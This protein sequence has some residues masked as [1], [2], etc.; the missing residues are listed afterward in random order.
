MTTQ[1]K[2]N[3]ADNEILSLAIPAAGAGLTAL[4]H[5]W[6]DT[7]WIG[8]SS[9]GALGVAA[10]GVASFTV[11][12]YGS[13]GS[14]LIVGL[15]AIVGRYCGAGRLAGACYTGSQGL[16]GAIWLAGICSL[17]GYFLAPLFFQLAGAGDGLLEVG[18]PYVRVYWGAGLPILLGYAATGIFRGHGD[19]RTP[20]L[21]GLVGLALN[22]VLDPVF[23]FGLG[24]L[25]AMGVE[26][27]AW[28]TV[29]C[30]GA[31]TLLMLWVLKKRGL[32]APARP[33]DEELRLR[34]DTPLSRPG[35]LGLDFAVLRRLVRIGQ[36]VAMAGIFFSLVYLLLARIVSATGGPTSVAA[37]S[38]GH[39]GEGLAWVFYTGYSAAA[40]SLVARYMGE[41]RT[42]LAE[43]LAWRAVSQ[44]AVLS[45]IWGGALFFFGE[46]IA[47]WFIDSKAADHE[48]VVRE[49]A[50]YFKITSWS[51]V[52]Q[53][54]DLVLGGAFSGAGL[55]LSPMLLSASITATR[56]PLAAWV[57]LGEKAEVSDIWWVIA[58]TAAIKGVLLILWFRRG[59]WKTR[60]V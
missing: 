28:A 36:P 38:I 41:G 59:K 18:T 12:I 29:I 13:L 54:C 2:S 26:G 19:T 51:L 47:A 30:S 9:D 35:R 45:L 27:A 32:L 1:Q 60:C 5:T 33:S 57:T 21:M 58:S 56:V 25:P 8:W 3:L 31:S 34:E 4:A 55:T 53:S 52:F 48:Q 43:K 37:L 16:R 44:C 22:A 40:S 24:P 15:T 23:I 17:A 20:F 14:L 10:L 6:V 49:A 46:H 11:W 7:A 50:L 39:R 42:G